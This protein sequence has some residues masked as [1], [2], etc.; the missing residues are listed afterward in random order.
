MREDFFFRIHVV[1]IHVP[2][3]RERPDDIQLLVEHFMNVNR[4]GDTAPLVPA[5]M[6]RALMN[7]HWPGNIRELQNV[8]QR[9][10]VLG[11][12]DSLQGSRIDPKEYCGPLYSASQQERRSLPEVL[13]KIEKEMIAEVLRETLWHRT[14]AARILGI[15]RRTLFKRIERY[16]LSSP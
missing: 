14:K 5:E 9:F 1:P 12:F 3:L 8:I 6:M 16:S 10:M 13:S 2:P 4:N 11:E 7:H 15:N